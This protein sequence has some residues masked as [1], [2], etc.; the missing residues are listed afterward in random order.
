MVRRISLALVLIALTAPFVF[1]DV[2]RPPISTPRPAID[3]RYAPIIVWLDKALSA[4]HEMPQG[5]I[6]DYALKNITVIY[7]RLNMPEC[8]FQTAKEIVAAE[9][10]DE[11]LQSIAVRYA[12]AG[13]Y[14]E[15]IDA[16][17]EIS[18][19]EM[20]Y[21]PVSEIV[22]AMIG[23][24]RYKE[25]VEVAGSFCGP[26]WRANVMARVAVLRKDENGLLE[27]IRYGYG[28]SDPDQRA[29]AIGDI[30]GIMV[31]A[32]R[33][34]SAIRVAFSAP[35]SDMRDHALRMISEATYDSRVAI[36]TLALTPFI[37]DL[38]TRA[39]TLDSIS[40]R[41]DTPQ[42]HALIFR[43]AIAT[44][45]AIK[46]PEERR[47][48]LIELSKV[49]AFDGLGKEAACAALL[50]GLND[51]QAMA[52][53]FDAC[54]ESNAFDEAKALAAK[55]D[56]PYERANRLMR[57]AYGQK[58]AGLAK[59]AVATY[60]DA[61]TAAALAKPADMG[62]RVF[63]RPEP[64][65]FDLLL[66]CA[67]S[68]NEAGSPEEAKKTFALAIA[69]ARYQ[70][71]PSA[72]YYLYRI[73]EC[74]QRMGDGKA[75][76]E[77]ESQ[78]PDGPAKVSM[79]CG[80]FAR[81]AS[82][83]DMDAARKTSA[84]AM[85]MAQKIGLYPDRQNSFS[86]LAVTQA[87]SKMFNESLETL[88]QIDNPATRLRVL[89]EI[90]PLQAAA[91]DSNGAASSFEEAT[92][93]CQ[94]VG[95]DANN[96][97]NNLNTIARLQA[98]AHLDEEAKKTLRLALDLTD[99]IEDMRS[100]I[101]LLCAIACIQRQ[102]GDDAEKTFKTA[103]QLALNAKTPEDKVIF[104]FDVSGGYKYAG[105]LDDSSRLFF[106]ARDIAKDMD[107]R[108]VQ[109]YLE[110]IAKEQLYRGMFAQAF[111]NVAAIKNEKMRKEIYSD[112]D[113]SLWYETSKQDSPEMALQLLQGQPSEARAFYC[114]SIA[115]QLLKGLR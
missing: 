12:K 1:G 105:L 99:K 15:S 110:Y 34:V 6:R 61:T 106:L 108:Q 18:G 37:E 104:L 94:K 103:E 45:D 93:M 58:Q 23:A 50:G 66:A 10:K 82:K 97:A 102:V 38:Q 5:P 76:Q 81:Q 96:V 70:P 14:A 19:V 9:Y 31:R 13:N 77:L 114:I 29:E 80:T 46:K 83:G 113:T 56:N 68:Q 49:A 87:R 52:E 64:T 89:E 67:Y 73:V 47:E 2:P 98:A 39:Y 11:L 90:A 22:D 26:L 59:E 84:D 71:S 3:I 78:I 60:T 16:V 107:S 92:R 43:Q 30:C 17:K 88:K 33:Y 91:G 4:A 62:N 21:Y 100:K 112:F 75:A 63:I 111:V 20:R 79:L 41:M 72:E 53:I 36:F 86:N 109:E 42:E 25:A 35:N 51:P 69:V 74:M 40:R 28:I 27:A 54:I 7:L 44:A 95:G 57:V 101:G 85:A 48:T 8:A 65:A 115:K 24:H 32:G 55:E